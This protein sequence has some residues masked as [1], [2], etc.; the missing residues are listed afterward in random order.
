M[1]QKASRWSLRAVLASL[2][3]SFLLFVPS[4]IPTDA[5]PVVLSTGI[6]LAAQ[7]TGVHV[8]RLNDLTAAAATDP[9]SV[10]YLSTPRNFAESADA[11]MA[12]HEGSEQLIHEHI[13]Q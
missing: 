8:L 9:K 4:S 2:A 11:C 12:L 10:L 5:A 13:F 6:L 3:P 1:R 7:T